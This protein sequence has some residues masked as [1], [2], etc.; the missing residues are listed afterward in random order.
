MSLLEKL[1]NRNLSS[2]INNI[3]NKEETSNII[4]INQGRFRCKKC[5]E[6]WTFT[7][8]NEINCNCGNVYK[9]RKTL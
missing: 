3:N 8:I 9:Y 6:L 1:K 7:N 2:T 4:F 5:G